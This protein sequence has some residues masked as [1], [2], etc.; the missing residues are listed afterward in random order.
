M[1]TMYWTTHQD[2]DLHKCHKLL[3]YIGGLS[4]TSIKWKTSVDSEPE[5]EHEPVK[6]KADH[7]FCPRKPQK[8]AS[9]EVHLNLNLRSTI[10]IPVAK[11]TPQAIL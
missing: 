2:H 11:M 1:D 8:S 5:P 9:C 6:R 4:F 3:G 7:N 10:F